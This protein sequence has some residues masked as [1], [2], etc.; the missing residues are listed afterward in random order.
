MQRCA[1][2]RQLRPRWAA[3]FTY[4]ICISKVTE[5]VKEPRDRGRERRRGLAA[6]CDVC[7]RACVYGHGGERVGGCLVG[8]QKIGVINI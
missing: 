4:A 8:W 7:E 5:R 1:R 6:V 3:L 2:C